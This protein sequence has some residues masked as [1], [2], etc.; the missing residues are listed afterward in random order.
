MGGET[1]GLDDS[2]MRRPTAADG[3]AGRDRRQDETRQFTLVVMYVSMSIVC[4]L[5]RRGGAAQPYPQPSA[6]ANST[7]VRTAFASPLGRHR[8]TAHRSARELE[9]SRTRAACAPGALRAA[10]CS[11][12]GRRSAR[13]RRAGSKFRSSH[14]RTGPRPPHAPA[15]ETDRAAS[16]RPARCEHRR[17]PAE[18]P[19]VAALDASAYRPRVLTAPCCCIALSS[20]SAR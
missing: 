18:A 16:R 2:S 4:Q 10:R 6:N 20:D 14:L 1:R 19:L 7:R 11:A 3:S 5:G 13:A 17:A 8:R 9:S 12:R 15:R